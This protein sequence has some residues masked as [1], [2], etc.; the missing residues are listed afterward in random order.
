MITAVSKKPTLGIDETGQPV[1][2]R[3]FEN[4]FTLGN[5]IDQY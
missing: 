5:S 3:L 2:N 4:T 1:T